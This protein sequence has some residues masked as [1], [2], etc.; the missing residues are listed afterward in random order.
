MLA[1]MRNGRLAEIATHVGVSESTVS[2]VLNGKPGV[3]DATRAR[4]LTAV[5]VLGYS[6][7]SHL[8]AQRTRMVA[9]V[10]PDLR[11]PVF[12]AFADMISGILPL[13]GFVPITCAT[14]SAG[15][16][17]AQYVEI[18]L[19]RHVAG[20][21]F[22]SCLHAVTN[23]EH[24][25]YRMLRERG[26]PMAVVNG[27]VDDLDVPC[28]STDD[29]TAVNLAVRH[30][31]S[32]GHRR[33]GLAISADDHVPSA[34]KVAAFQEEVERL[35]NGRGGEALV[36]RTIF[37]LEGG[38]AAATRLIQQGATAIICGSD[39][40]ALGATRAAD[41]LGL[42]VPQHIS[43]VGYDDSMSLSTG[44]PAI[45]T[46]RQPIDA[47]SRA[48]VELISSQASGVAVPADE[49]VFEPDLV[50]RSSTGAATSSP[51][52]S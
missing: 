37:S 33:M 50:V 6:R 17:E 38:S 14:E 3:S 8:R 16:S 35:L 10:I 24:A 41:R 47:I 52:W 30:L 21:I 22:I 11:N 42:Q 12:P 20:M 34:R 28:V 36:D 25:H 31:V 27:V 49:I 26:I 39:V 48:A 13:R 5:D 40:M 32:L 45:T 29:A 44:G 46:V 2:R 1:S 19:D 18:L 4:V 51:N 23:A 9:I 15:I 43:V 7:P